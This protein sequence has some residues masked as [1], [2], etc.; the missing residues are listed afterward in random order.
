MNKPSDTFPEYRALDEKS[1]AGFVSQI[2]TVRETLG[3]SPETWGAREVGDGNL[4]LVFIVTGT[5]G[6]VVVKQ[7]LPY[8][9][10]VGEAWAL[11]L[12]RAYFE[13]EALTEEAKF[14]PHLLPQR[15]HY[16]SKLAAIVMEFL[17]PHIILRKGFI[18]GIRYPRLAAD[19]A[20]FMAQ[21]LF[22]TSDLYLGAATKKQR[23][24]IFCRNTELC[25]ITEEL[26]F[27]DPYRIAKLNRWTTPQLDDI[28]EKFRQ[29]GPLKT[30]AQRLK[31]KFL[32]TAEA[33]IHG[34]LHSG[35][36]M[37]TPEDTRVIDPEFAFYGPMGFD[38]GA[39]I[40][41]LLLAFFSQEGHES[42][43]G[44]RKEYRAWLLQTIEETWN[45]FE[46]RF[47]ELWQENASGDAYHASLFADPVSSEALATEQRNYL[48]RLFHDSV[49]FAGVKMIRRIL[50]LAHVEDLEAIKD[51]DLRARCE[52]KALRLGRLLVIESESFSTITEVTAAA[53]QE[54]S[55]H[56]S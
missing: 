38:S 23:M 28:A 19:I 2:Q 11:P 5:K 44:Q 39:V 25:K 40:G 3:G 17:S 37:A 31:L 14:V 46:Q 22:K 30:A 52:R 6:A 51:P 24:A 47:L 36:I 53:R 41:N 21:T 15:Y 7:A 50:G 43:P 32:T 33:L 42:S 54:Y 16:D 12:E 55:H 27:T 45:R 49:G 10:C 8:V 18:Q 29:D 48:R 9:R 13:N 4:N 20:E 34:D 56:E 26:V 35:S 1:V